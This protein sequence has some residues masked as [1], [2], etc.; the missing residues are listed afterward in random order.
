MFGNN[1]LTEDYSRRR[2]N[3]SYARNRPHH[4]MSTKNLI[5][6]L[7]NQDDYRTLLR[8]VITPRVEA[9]TLRASFASLPFLFYNK[10]WKEGG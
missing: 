1:T 6:H 10:A 4:K 8:R 2:R 3:K 9:G 7:L 5:L